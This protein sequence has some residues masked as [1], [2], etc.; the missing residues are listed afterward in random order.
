MSGTENTN[1]GNFANRYVPLHYEPS[2]T[3]QCCY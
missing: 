1:P 2:L 3:E